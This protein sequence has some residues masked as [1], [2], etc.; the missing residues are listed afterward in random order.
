M[1]FVQVGAE[2]VEK[3]VGMAAA[4]VAQRIQACVPVAVFEPAVQVDKTLAEGVIDFR[5]IG[6]VEVV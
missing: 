1:K 2:E 3:G 6:P 4:E 5:C